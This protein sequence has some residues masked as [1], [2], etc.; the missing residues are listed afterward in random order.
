MNAL[1]WNVRGLGNDRTFQ[2]LREYVQHY[3]PQLVFLSETL[4]SKP[5]MERIKVQ[6]G[7][8]GMLI[9]EKEGKSGGLCL[10][11]ST[12]V[13]V[14]LLSG[15]KGHIDVIVTSHNSLSW[16]F[17]G[18]YGN[19]DSSLRTHSWDLLKR[20]GD[21]HSLPWLC[22]GD[23]NEI[24]FDY[25]KSG[26][27]SRSPS[28][29]Q[30]FRECLDHC[31]LADLGYRGP[32]FT[33]Y[34]GNSNSNLIQERLDRMLGNHSW[35]HLFPNSV[36]RHLRFRGSD[37]RPLLVELLQE[38]ES[39]SIGKRRRK[40]RFYF[41]EA[42]AEEAGCGEIISKH[43]IASPVRNLNDITAKLRL[44]ASD[45]KVW[46]L[47]HFRRLEESVKRKKLAFDLLDKVLSND[48]WKEHQRLEKELDVLRYK[49]ERYWQQRSKD[50]WLKC[51]DRNS[52]FFHQKASARQVK[53]RMEGLFDINEQW[54]TDEEGMA[55]IAVNYFQTLF[56]SSSPSISNLARVLDTVE[57]R[58]T[59]DINAQLEKPFIPADVKTAIFQMAP[60]KSPGAD[61]MSALFYHN[62]WHVVGDEVA[63]ACLGVLNEGMSLASTNETLISLI[64]KVKN[65]IRIT[66]YRPIS[67]CNVIYKI[68]SKMLSNRL[69][70]VMNNV[71]SE[72]QSA[73]IPGR[74]ISDNAIIGFECL[75]AI[76]RKRSKKKGYL[77]LKLDMAKAFDRVEWSFVQG[78]ML[79]L[80][81]SEVWTK[82]VMACVTSVSYSVLINGAKFGQLFPTRGLRQ[83][84]PLSPY[85]FLLCAEGLSSLF[86]HFEA[87]G[88]IQGMR[89]G[90]NG[91]I[92]SHL[93]FADDSLLFSEASTDSCLAV[94]EALTWY[95]TASGQLVSYS[96]SAVCFGPNV[97]ADHAD[98][99]TASL[100]VPKVGCHE[101]YLGLPCL[102]GKNK[103]RLFASIK[104]RV[105]NKLSGW[106]S[107]FLSTGGREVL[108]KAIIQSIPTY[109]MSMFKLPFSLIKELHR[110]CAQFWWGGNNEKKRMHW[111]TW[112]RLCVHKLN[113]GMGFRDMR[114]FNKAILAKQA[115][116][117]LTCPSS[118]AA[119]VLQ[120]FYFTNSTFLQVRKNSSASFVWRSIL[121]GRELLMQGS[122]RKIGSGN[123][124]YIYH[125]RWPPRDGSFRISSPRVLGELSKV[126]LLKTAT[127]QWNSSLIADSFHPDE[128]AAILS[129]PTLNRPT[130]DSLTWHYN[131][132]GHY[133]VRSGYWVAKGGMET[134]S[135]S[136]SSNHIPWWKQFW[137]LQIPAK[138]R[139]FVWKAYNDWIPTAVNLANHG[140]PTHKRCLICTEAN[141]TTTHGLWECMAMKPLTVMCKTIFQLNLPSHCSM[142]ELL[143]SASEC[144]KGDKMELLCVLLWRIWFH[145]NKWI[146]EKIWLDDNSC[147]AWAQQHLEDF[148]TASNKQFIPH[149]PIAAPPWKPPEMGIVKINTDAAWCKRTKKFGLGVVIRDHFGS[150]LGSA[151]TPVS[152]SVSVDVAEGWALERGAWLAK[153][154][155]FPAI[156]LESD[157]LGVVMALQ[158]QIHFISEFSFVSDSIYDHCNTFQQ[159]SFSYTPRTSN[160]VAHNLA[161][162]ALSLA[163]EQIWRGRGPDC[164]A[165]MAI[166]DIQPLIS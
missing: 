20:L 74:L 10:Y 139:I 98:Q 3:S 71:I 49:E 84:D 50:T 136:S 37:H 116:R 125:D 128:A 75:H 23:L 149:I 103:R 67:L 113:G 65:P 31:G 69:R 160:Q 154:L 61:G 11:W 33:W 88:R 38:H 77:A 157:C 78:I 85:L 95:E 121:W 130:A 52:K 26:G 22:G 40:G 146:H 89:C 14:Q 165:S 150:I 25:E 13:D 27:G 117:I 18:F 68:I 120:G 97:A 152:S 148:K 35:L 9:W 164:I 47:E 119:R 44:C 138:I 124:T 137:R 90:Q 12:G 56:A 87:A 162:L 151:A 155:G 19:P 1:V 24:L 41:E 135:S 29:M 132:R 72:E 28:L 158:Q 91:P 17:T 73:F 43:W 70:L 83:G 42:W 5:R 15:S 80:G 57:P 111:C 55:R 94:K 115:W 96:K 82:K 112:E 114:L 123:D 48:N 129:L 64:P 99:M 63:T 142:K 6:L 58:V 163:D 140:V 145:R 32:L 109:S 107:K 108:T 105:W 127:G 161:K 76:K 21:C 122:R 54:C 66:D 8:S 30:N 110:L 100:G 141:D 126:S 7:F 106:K 93:F 46:N 104:D 36:V 166:A 53:N 101:K 92:I 4:C 134:I 2:I 16:R 81:F 118:L 51:G 62:Y 34:R 59:Q 153:Y 39:S 156:E 133:T 79:K 86:H 60:S 102:S 144:L 147:L 159:F 131:K 45:L 143:R